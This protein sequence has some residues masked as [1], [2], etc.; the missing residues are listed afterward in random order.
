M[1]RAEIP[2]GSVLISFLK[3][4][5]TLNTEALLNV[6]PEGISTRVLDQSSIALV[7]AELSAVAAGRWE[8]EGGGPIRIPINVDDALRVIGKVRR[9]DA[10]LVAYD[11][12]N[13]RLWFE[14]FDSAPSKQR[15]LYV[16]IFDEVK[17]AG[18]REVKAPNIG[19]EA[20]ATLALRP[21]LEAVSDCK[22]FD[23]T[24]LKLTIGPE[25][26][27]LS[28]KG[29]WGRARIIIWKEGNYIYS[30][31]AEKPVSAS[32]SPYYMEMM[33]RAG[34]EIVDMV[35]LKLADN[36]PVKFE[37]SSY[38]VNLSYYLPPKSEA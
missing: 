34:S 12:E 15:R 18:A 22:I 9:G 16:E 37:F 33:L 31:D 36:G 8:L 38:D 26:V 29:E 1:F 17:E 32:F 28:S 4:V 14:V 6:T 3:A 11:P 5:K 13:R 23:R 7:E 21:L 10:L 27:M 35:T 25:K 2:D 30:L 19:F 20:K 24:A